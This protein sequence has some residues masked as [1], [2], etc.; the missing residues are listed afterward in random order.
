MQPRHTQYVQ[1]AIVAALLVGCIAVLL[2]FVGTL[3]FAIVVVVT[4]WPLYARLLTALRQRHSVAAL[5]MALLLVLLLACWLFFIFTGFGA[6]LAGLG[7]DSSAFT[8]AGFDP[9]PTMTPPM[10][11]HVRQRRSRP[12]TVPVS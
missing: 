4:A 12:M 11:P 6:A 2:P 7:L 8:P 5:I 3:M 9:P 1:I 10:C